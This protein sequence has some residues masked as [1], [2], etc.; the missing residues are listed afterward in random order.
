MNKE[1]R[2]EIEEKITLYDKLM[3]EISPQ[4][5]M[6]DII[7][8]G[9][10]GKDFYADCKYPSIRLNVNASQYNIMLWTKGDSADAKIDGKTTS[11]LLEEIS[12]V[13]LKFLEEKTAKT[14]EKIHNI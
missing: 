12:K 1:E 2:Q 13:I 11:S 14:I 8:Q 7:K 6:I 10:L 4:L 5:K 3:E 9:I